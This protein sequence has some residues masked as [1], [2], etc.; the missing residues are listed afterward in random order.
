MTK[1]TL[2]GWI[3]DNCSLATEKVAYLVQPPAQRKHKI[4]DRLGNPLLEEQERIEQNYLKDIKT[5]L[6]N[7][8][9]HGYEPKW[10]DLVETMMGWDQRYG[11]PKRHAELAEKARKAGIDVEKL[12]G[13]K[14]APPAS[15]PSPTAPAPTAP[16]APA[17]KRPGRLPFE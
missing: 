14:S 15:R 13:K 8:E 2:A 3:R 1:T 11:D 16:A 12:Q 5:A 17:R 10:M 7:P 6:D 9:I 4:V